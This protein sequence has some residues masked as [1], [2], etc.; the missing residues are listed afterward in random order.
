M[1]KRTIAACAA[2]V[3]C[4]LVQAQVPSV[5]FSSQ[6]LMPSPLGI[7]LMA[8]QWL[9]Q[10]RRQV[11]YIEVAGEGFTAEE[12]RQ[13]GFR[14][15][16]EQ[17]IGSLIASE[18][19]V[20][21]SRIKRDEIISY[22][23]GFVERFEIVETRNTTRGVQVVMKVWVARSALANRLLNESKT[24]SRV[25]GANAS[26]AVA[27]IQHE[28]TQGDRI[29]QTVLNDFP[30]RAFDI[31]V[32]QTKVVLDQRRQA[33][34]EIPLE[35]RWNYNYLTSLANAVDATNHRGSVGYIRVISGYPPS[36]SGRWIGWSTEAGYNDLGKIYQI[37]NSMVRSGPAVLITIKNVQGRPEYRQC[38]R[39]PELDHN[40][41]GSVP[42]RYFVEFG[43]N[44]ANINGDFVFKG[45]ITVPVTAQKLQDL[46]QVSAEVVLG[47]SCPN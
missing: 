39:W 2:I 44:R 46:D 12:A 36:G 14:L 40:V 9:L 18:T 22:A 3:A 8:G 29:L 19:H 15:A 11:Y 13:N 31:K 20:E 25:D 28:R 32:L 41:H 35:I 6:M 10:D 5:N 26:A 27:T 7:V 30:R 17:A 16:V 37:A 33:Q 34:L 23:S 21:N 47:N 24:E 45:L 43:N 4:G 42:S 1:L 38:Y